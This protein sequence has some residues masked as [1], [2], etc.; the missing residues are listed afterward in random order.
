[1]SWD[2]KLVTLAVCAIFAVPAYANVPSAR[3]RAYH[4]HYMREARC[5]Y[6]NP[7]GNLITCDGWRYRNTARGWDHS[8][9]DLAYLPSEFACSSK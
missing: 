3:H 8:C 6:R 2:K 1:M 4:P 5:V 9:L 7:D